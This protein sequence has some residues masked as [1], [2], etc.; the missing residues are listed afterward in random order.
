MFTHSCCPA[1]RQRPLGMVL[2]SLSD[3]LVRTTGHMAW[4][5]LDRPRASPDDHVI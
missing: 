2:Q 4:G 1:P 3:Q 5:N